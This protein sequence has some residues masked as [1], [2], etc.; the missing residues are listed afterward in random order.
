MIDRA[1]LENYGYIT[2]GQFRRI[3]S[4]KKSNQ[5]LFNEEETMDAF[6]AMGGDEGGEGKIDTKMLIQVLKRDF[7]MTID[8]EKLVKDLDKD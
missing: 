5:K 2:L 6:M 3:V 7:E 4:N 1:D 8:I